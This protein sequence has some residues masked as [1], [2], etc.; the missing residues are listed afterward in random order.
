MKKKKEKEPQYFISDT[1]MK[2]LNYRVYYMKPLEK[3]MYFL[4][5]FIVGAA[6]GYLFYGGLAVDE[7]GNPTKTTYILNI[8][9]S[10]IVGIAAGIAFIPIRTKTIIK[11]R[12]QD[13]KL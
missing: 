3:T 13:L 1:N 8:T 5:A 4:M 2:T 11:K 12:T 9:I 7:F 10:G 6:V